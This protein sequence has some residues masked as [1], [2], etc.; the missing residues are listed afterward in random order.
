MLRWL[1]PTAALLLITACG[2][3]EQKSRYSIDASAK[4]EPVMD[5]HCYLQVTRGT[6]RIEGGDTLPGPVDSLYIKLDLL[7]ELANGEYNWVPQEKDRM[8]GYF[9][10]SFEDSLV[11]AVY[12]Y[13]AEGKTQKMEV[14]FKIEDRSLRVATGEM[15]ESEGVYLF[16]D[17]SQVSY[18]EPIPEVNCK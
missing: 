5:S 15:E 10:G 12:T 4:G 8:K 2:H 6:A 3:S 9:Q 7:G 18:G 16:K 17:K 14:L 13:T 11:T 1:V